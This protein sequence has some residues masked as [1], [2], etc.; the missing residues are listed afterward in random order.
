MARLGMVGGV[1]VAML[2]AGWCG[3]ASAVLVAE[4]T[5]DDGTARGVGPGGV[6]GTLRGG[7]G[8]APG[9]SGLALSLDGTGGYVDFGTPP[10]AISSLTQGAISVWFQFDRT[11]GPAD[12]LPILYLGDGVGG[13]GHSAFVLEVGHF[14]PGDTK[15]Y[16]TFISNN[17]V[18]PLC[19]DTGQ[20]LQPGAWYNFVGVVG[21]DG[22]TGYLNGVELTGRHYNFGTAGSTEF[23]DDIADPQVLWVGRGLLAS[24]PREHYFSGL[25][26]EVKIYDTP[27]TAAEIRSA[28]QAVLNGQDPPAAVPEPLTMAGVLAGIGLAARALSARRMGKRGPSV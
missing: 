9:I 22:N 23:L 15:L 3:P 24:F 6:T 25:I 1:V 28:Y 26:D 21:P 20:N 10:A 4:W 14:D 8:F 5:F 11:T 7:A 18:L 27:L 13:S 17:M 12:I 16:F 2:A 19:F